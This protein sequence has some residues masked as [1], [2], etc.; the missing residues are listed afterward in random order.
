MSVQE[1]DEGRTVFLR[2]AVALALNGHRPIGL[3]PLPV[4]PLSGTHTAMLFP[5]AQTPD[6]RGVAGNA[7]YVSLVDVGRPVGIDRRRRFRPLPSWSRS[8]RS[9]TI[10]V[11]RSGTLSTSVM[12]ESLVGRGGQIAGLVAAS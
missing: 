2:L 8:R 4:P 11:R 12:G 6:D 1:R 3:R 7:G 9:G 5:T 10:E